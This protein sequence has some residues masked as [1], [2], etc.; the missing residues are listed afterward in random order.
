MQIE[1]DIEILQSEIHLEIAQERKAQDDK[2][3]INQLIKLTP[4]QCLSIL[5][6]EVGEMS[7]AINDCRF[8]IGKDSYETELIQ[9]AAVAIQSIVV[10]R[11]QRQS[12]E[13]QESS[14][15]FEKS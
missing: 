8:G 9:I 5:V 4:H 10:A 7:A 13:L 14:Y 1:D 2:F 12:I 15:D 6:E 3:G 11:L